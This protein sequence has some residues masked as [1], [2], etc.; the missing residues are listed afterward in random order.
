MLA[1]ELETRT[2]GQAAIIASSVEFDFGRRRILRDVSFQVPAGE[3]TVLVGP[4]GAGKS[5]AFRLI[6]GE[7]T[8]KRGT[9]RFGPNGYG[10]SDVADRDI[11]LV[12]QQIALVERLSLRE[13]LRLFAAIAGVRHKDR[14]SRI[15]EAMEAVGLAERA[16]DHVKNLSGGQ[17]R[18]ANVAAA[19]VHRP[20]V[21]MLDEPTA[22]VDASA[23]MQLYSL[24]RE[25]RQSGTAILM[26]THDLAEADQLA[27]GVVVLVDGAVVSTGTYE[28]VT[29]SLFGGHL[30][31]TVVLA[32]KSAS[33]DLLQ[34]D[35]LTRELTD[36]GL[37]PQSDQPQIWDGL[38]APTAAARAQILDMLTRQDRLI[39]D[40]KIRRPGLDAVVA[41][42]RGHSGFHPTA[43]GS[44]CASPSSAR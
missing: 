10:P 12:P 28:E 30:E 1:A 19:L 26:T 25:R 9:I 2:P 14:A 11:G 15:T 24:L 6:V 41:H 43:A 35:Q 23:R 40:C 37:S 4:N 21:L 36:L 17:R 5:T 18:L 8:P 29:H 20:A 22:G 39:I 32:P 42:Y 27:D 7:L 16:N 44:T 34:H 31:C 38:V 3:I 33:P 13:N